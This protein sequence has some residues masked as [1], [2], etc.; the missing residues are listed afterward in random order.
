[1]KDFVSEYGDSI[2]LAIMGFGVLGGL[3]KIM[4]LLLEGGW[5]V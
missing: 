3:I 5:S 1:M 2:V 4:N